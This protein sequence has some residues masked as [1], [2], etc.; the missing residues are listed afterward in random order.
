MGNQ[1]ASGCDSVMARSHV[2]YLVINPYV[3][4]PEDAVEA[5][6]TVK[7]EAITWLQRTKANDQFG[8]TNN[9]RLYRTPDGKDAE[10]T[11]LT[12]VDL[13]G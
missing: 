7:H 6:F 10:L 8:Y 2:I 4:Y 12:L 5:V 1:D 13:D 9:W 3:V 11:E